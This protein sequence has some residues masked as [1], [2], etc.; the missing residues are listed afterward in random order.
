MEKEF[1]EAHKKTGQIESCLINA[2]EDFLL[3]EAKKSADGLRLAAQEAI[4]FADH[5]MNMA[6]LLENRK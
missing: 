3:K 5:C 2:Q 6:K 1:Q 4:R